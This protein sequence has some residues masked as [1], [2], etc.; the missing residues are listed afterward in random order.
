MWAVFS[1][2]VEAIFSVCWEGGIF[3]LPPPCIFG[4]TPKIVI[5]FYFTSQIFIFL[6]D[7]GGFNF[8]GNLFFLFLR[9]G[10]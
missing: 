7:R 4:G 9:V 5:T 2:H 3:G 6:P 10:G 1:L 8:V